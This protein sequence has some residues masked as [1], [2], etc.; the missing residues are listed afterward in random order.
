MHN[1]PHTIATKKIISEIIK[2]QYRKGRTSWNKGKRLNYEVWN[3]GT[4]GIMKSNSGSFKKGSKGN[5]KGGKIKTYHGY[6]SI[7]KP[8]HPNATK[9]GRVPEHRLV[10][11][12]IIGRYLD[13]K[14]VVHHINGIKDD[15][16]PENLILFNGQYSHK[17]F[18]M[19]K[20]GI[21]IGEIIYDGRNYERK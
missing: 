3:K 10:V 7:Y 14:E 13:P 19:I 4:K 11:E 1:K 16:R 21:K 8:E 5:W 18:E 12:K 17:K 2:E 6:A 20:E 9:Q 15:N